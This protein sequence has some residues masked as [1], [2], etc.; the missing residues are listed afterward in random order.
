MWSP[1][2]SRRILIRPPSWTW[3]WVHLAS[4]QPGS[5]VLSG[6]DLD[7][8][9]T[10]ESALGCLLQRR[11][12]K[13]AGC[14]GTWVEGCKL[15]FLICEAR[16]CGGTPL[17]VGDCLYFFSGNPYCMF[18]GSSHE[19]TPQELPL[20]PVCT[21]ST[22]TLSAE[23]VHRHLWGWLVRMSGSTC[24]LGLPDAV[25]SADVR[26]LWSISSSLIVT[27]ISSQKMTD[28]ERDAEQRLIRS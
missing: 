11:A 23:L 22:P 28:G 5:E 1:A 16:C 25:L 19:V 8:P 12:S 13:Q 4:P 3:F 15:V 14:A 24:S 27:L 10:P 2:A 20:C 7:S 18:A 6:W 17:G 9:A 21:E 26:Q